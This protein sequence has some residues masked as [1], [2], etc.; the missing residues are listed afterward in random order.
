M[1]KKGKFTIRQ[2][3]TQMIVLQQQTLNMVAESQLKNNDLLEKLL[4]IILIESS[5]KPSN[6]NDKE[7]E[8]GSQPTDIESESEENK[9]IR[10]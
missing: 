5:D 7:Q 8:S 4:D 2:L 1:E 10:K 3:L 9:T 6:E